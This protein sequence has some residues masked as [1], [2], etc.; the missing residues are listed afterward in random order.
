MTVDL[1]SYT[2]YKS[3][4]PCTVILLFLLP[5]S[6]RY[7]GRSLTSLAKPSYIHQ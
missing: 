3:L 4:A 7:R 5:Y 6:A 1:I 2:Y